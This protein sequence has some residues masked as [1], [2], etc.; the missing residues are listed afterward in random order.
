MWFQRA[1]RLAT[2]H[3]SVDLIFPAALDPVVWGTE[4]STTAEAL[5]LHTPATRRDNGAD[6]VFSWATGDPLMGAPG[7]GSNGGSAPAPRTAAS[8]GPSCGRPVAGRLHQAIIDSAL[9]DE[10]CLARDRR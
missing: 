4:T 10:T 2:S 7:T 6:V 5:P 1:V 8:R 9:T 3:L